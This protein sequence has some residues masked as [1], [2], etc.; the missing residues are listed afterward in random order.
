MFRMP[1]KSTCVM[2]WTLS[3][4]GCQSVKYMLST[5]MDDSNIKKT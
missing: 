4:I 1:E 5:D 3:V 2:N